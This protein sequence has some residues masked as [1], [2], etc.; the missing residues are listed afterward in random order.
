MEQDRDEPV[1]PLSRIPYQLD[2]AASVMANDGELWIALKEGGLLRICPNA[3]GAPSP[4][5]LFP[6]AIVL[7]MYKDV[8]GSFW[9]MTDGMGVLLVTPDQIDMR[10]VV[11]GEQYR[12]RAV[13]TLCTMPEGGIAFGT[14]NGSLHRYEVGGQVELLVP[15]RSMGVRDRVRDIQLDLAGR[16]WFTTDSWIGHLSG[17]GHRTITGPFRSDA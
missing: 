3:P 5:Q 16:L 12:T 13:S 14:V 2:A 7:G 11:L 8:D 4:E 1:F 9:I 17:P 10:L 6:N 15:S